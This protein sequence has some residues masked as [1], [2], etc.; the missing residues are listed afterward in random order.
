MPYRE[1]DVPLDVMTV[2]AKMPTTY[3]ITKARLVMNETEK[4]LSS[5]RDERGDDWEDKV[6]RYVKI[7]WLV[8]KICKYIFKNILFIIFLS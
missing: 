7:A 5:L 4:Q 8:L 6:V 1:P 3:D 2:H